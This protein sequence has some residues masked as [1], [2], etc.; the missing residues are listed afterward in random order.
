[1]KS[2]DG[3]SALA[4]PPSTSPPPSYADNAAVPDI[5]AGFAQLNLSPTT[6]ETP[7]ADECIAHLKLLEAFSQLREDIGNRDGL[8][9]LF[10]ELVENDLAPESKSQLLA[11]MREKRWAIFVTLAAMRFETWWSKVAQGRMLVDVQLCNTSME[12]AL[13]DA[14]P[15]S[16]THDSLPPLG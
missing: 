12:R 10:D 5:T 6:S 2:A 8:Y 16:F 4:A 9:G 11:R 15:L 14:S 7:T 1:M 13:R 3:S